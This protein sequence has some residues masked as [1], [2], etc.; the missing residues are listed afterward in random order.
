MEHCKEEKKKSLFVNG[1]GK[2]REAERLGE[3]HCN[4]PGKS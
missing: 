3:S 1:A 4:N 2:R